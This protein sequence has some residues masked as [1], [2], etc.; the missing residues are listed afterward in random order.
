MPLHLNVPHLA[1]AAFTCMILSLA[2]GLF[3]GR[4]T[5]QWFAE[6][7][8][9]RWQLP[10]SAHFVVQALAYLIEGVILYRLL[11]SEIVPAL[12]V[13]ALATML[14]MMIAAEGA[15]AALLGL[16]SAEAGLAATLSFL[17]PLAAAE[18]TLWH[19]D[20]FGAKLLLP[21]C[22]WVVVYLVPWAV[23]V[24]RLNR[25]GSD[26]GTSAGA[27]VRTDVG[28]QVGTDAG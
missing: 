6:L 3:Q 27:K 23:S 28:T 11:E 21:Y 9:A 2:G 13:V 14:L 7:R 5:L 15:T 10:N 8:R 22:A 16:R 19:A 25:A 17:A 24:W 1:L 4:E 26:Y 12:R 18:F 20:R